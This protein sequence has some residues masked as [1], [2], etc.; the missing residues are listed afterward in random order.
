MNHIDVAVG[1]VENALMLP[2][3]DDDIYE[4]PVAERGYY[5]DHG[6]HRQV[7]VGLHHVPAEK[8]RRG[9]KNKKYPLSQPSKTFRWENGKKTTK[10][11]DESA[12]EAEGQDPYL[13]PAPASERVKFIL[14][15]SGEN[16]EEAGQEIP[17]LFTEL[18]EL[19]VHLDGNVEWKE[20]ARWYKYEEDVEE[21]GDRWSKP[22]VATLSLYSLFELRSSLMAG[23]VILDMDANTLSEIADNVLDNLISCNKLDE[24]FRVKVRDTLL[25]KHR[26]Q[27]SIGFR[28]NLSN[29]ISSRKS[30]NIFQNGLKSNP[31]NG[32]IG[33]HSNGNLVGS[34]NNSSNKL[35]TANEKPNAT[36]KLFRNFSQPAFP[37][38]GVSLRPHVSFERAESVQGHLVYQSSAANEDEENND[39]APAF[40][41]KLPPNA[42]ASNILVGEVDFL[43]KPITAFVRLAKS[44]I[45]NDL[46]EVPIP[47]RFLFIMLGPC[48]APGRYHEIGRAIST[49]MADEVFHDVAYKAKTREDLIAGIDEFLEQVTVLPPGEWDP[50]IRIPAP[51]NNG[52][53][54]IARRCTMEKQNL[55][56]H[57]EVLNSGG[58]DTGESTDGGDSPS[59]LTPQRKLFSALKNDIEIWKSRANDISDGLN[60][61]CFGT[62]FFIYFLTLSIIITLGEH[63]SKAT[64]GL[65]GTREHLLSL[66]ATG[67]L[68]SIFSTQPI[69]IISFVLPLSL[70]D[71]LLYSF[72][73]KLEIDYLS[74]RLW[75]GAW[76]IILIIL[77]V[78]F[79][80]SN[81]VR[82]LT[83]F[84]LE[85]FVVLAPLVLLG[86][87]FID[88]CSMLKEF[89][90]SVGP[91][92]NQTCQCI[93]YSTANTSS[94]STLNMSRPYLTETVLN[95]HFRDCL[96]KGGNILGDGCLHD[97][98]P[99]ALLLA[100][101]TIFLSVFFA[102]F[103]HF[104]YFTRQLNH[105]VNSFTTLFVILIMS[106]IANQFNINI[107]YLQLP[108]HYHPT[109]TRSSWF[110]PVMGTNE[111]WIIIAALIPGIF[112]SLLILI[113]QLFTA[114]HLN[115]NEQML[116]KRSSYH[117]DLLILVF[118]I[119]GASILGLPFTV[120]S[121]I[122]SISHMQSLT[123][124]SKVEDFIGGFIAIK[125]QR[126]SG[127]FIYLLILLTP[128]MKP[129]LRYI[130]HP[131]LH[132]ILLLALFRTFYNIQFAK[133]FALLFV[134]KSR[135]P[136]N[137]MYL[138]QV[139]LISANMFTVLQVV[140]T[141]CLWAV[142]A[143]EAA[144]VFP[145]TLM[146][147]IGVRYLVEYLLPLH[148]ILA[149]DEPVARVSTNWCCC[150]QKRSVELL[151]A[152][153][154][155]GLFSDE[156][157]VNEDVIPDHN[158]LHVERVS[159]AEELSK[160]A[161]WKQLM[162]GENSNSGIS[163]SPKIDR[164]NSRKRRKKRKPSNVNL[165]EEENNE[166]FFLDQTDS[167]F[168]RDS[169]LSRK[170]SSEHLLKKETNE[171]QME[172][173]SS[174][175]KKGTSKKSNNH[176]RGS[177]KEQRSQHKQSKPKPVITEEA[178]I[179]PWEQPYHSPPRK[180]FGLL[181]IPEDD[182]SVD[183]ACSRSDNSEN[184]GDKDVVIPDV[185][186]YTKK[187]DFYLMDDGRGSSDNSR[188][189]MII[190]DSPDESR[191]ASSEQDE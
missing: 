54:K 191:D 41:K 187:I 110:V 52:I 136:D 186:P 64:G 157:I 116:K 122:L 8:Q 31:S 167:Y 141:I 144:I 124:K 27:R 39:K 168:K 113:E 152:E 29:I 78:S 108:S 156:Q 3:I 82:Y 117:L 125:E 107:R 43:E 80:L 62:V 22:H 99:F 65:L 84:S 104:G 145:I 139:P 105:L 38:Q 14:G 131:V 92:T 87:G 56:T 112:L 44:S 120:A 1:E 173:G 5:D 184:V 130:P 93:K 118:G 32:V 134:P 140:C 67:I 9:T 97:T 69:V 20:T 170:N 103:R 42:E 40:M 33:N 162:H 114:G 72:C 35:T 178:A 135:H 74:F 37:T 142:R 155:K 61:H 28:R 160:T 100:L 66:G 59:S 71:S 96:E 21:G 70:F 146:L 151:M 115:H 128:L 30:T 181:K 77:Y 75:V 23:T 169:Q 18:E 166:D 19:C 132:G 109:G 51:I 60:L 12:S 76:S 57:V 13:L 164:Q 48:L 63:Q 183:P 53:G 165:K 85:I 15:G 2:N 36:P 126:L 7:Y 4:P 88:L 188:D 106:S 129:A 34:A 127:F 175:H 26:H 25:R 137:I 171:K 154:E 89:S 46:T 49:L 50:S 55:E 190:K 179:P 123:V 159:I 121:V 111:Y 91:F 68:Y 45:I 83:R 180:D 147:L 94:T 86:Y 95:I 176:E 11:V 158:I 189:D 153:V 150:K 6:E 119:A 24:M 58:S 102:S 148:D 138:R 174:K 98:Y 163:N 16:E 81:L 185:I 172:R 143:S 161:A 47:T 17:Q 133:R 177:F 79:N 182:C 73:S 149:I 10:Q 101:F 90:N